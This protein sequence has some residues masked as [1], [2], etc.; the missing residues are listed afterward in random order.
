MLKSDELGKIV[1]NLT[2]TE[3]KENV[4][5]TK[6]I[7]YYLIRN[8][9]TKFDKFEIEPEEAFEWA[10][11]DYYVNKFLKT[12]QIE[13]NINGKPAIQLTK[14]ND[15]EFQE[16]LGKLKFNKKEMLEKLYVEMEKFIRE[17]AKQHGQTELELEEC[18]KIANYLL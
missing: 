1:H 15:D 17:R 18:Y 4:G 11:S 7:Y 6:S 13:P 10:N 14:S 9:P 2:K 16:E 3:D 5:K 12:L 8:L